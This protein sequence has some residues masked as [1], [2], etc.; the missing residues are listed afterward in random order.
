MPIYIYNAAATPKRIRQA[1]SQ[2][3][4]SIPSTPAVH[5]NSLGGLR[6]SVYIP[7][8]IFILS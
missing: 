6:A 7:N 3:M 1:A 2:P 5:S 4:A 8:Q